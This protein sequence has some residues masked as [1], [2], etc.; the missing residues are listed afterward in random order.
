MKNKFIITAPIEYEQPRDECYDRKEYPQQYLKTMIEGKIPGAEVIISNFTEVTKHINTFTAKADED[1]QK[2]MN[3]SKDARNRWV[4]MGFRNEPTR[5]KTEY[6]KEI[7]KEKKDDLREEMRKKHGNSTGIRVTSECFT[8]PEGYQT[9]GT[10][11]EPEIK[12]DITGLIVPIGHADHGELF[13]IMFGIEG[14]FGKQIKIISDKYKKEKEKSNPMSYEYERKDY[15]KKV[16]S[17]FYSRYRIPVFESYKFSPSDRFDNAP[18]GHNL[19]W[20]GEDFMTEKESVFTR[21]PYIKFA[22]NKWLDDYFIYIE[23]KNQ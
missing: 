5:Y 14:L 13:Q 20:K 11:T 23:K 16:E 10:F 1:L 19:T 8:Y 12:T 9:L 4:E 3:A 15:H 6:E 21:E 18:V 2:M 7:W 17:F 22:F